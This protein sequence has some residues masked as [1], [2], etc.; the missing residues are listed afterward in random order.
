MQL[1]LFASLFLILIML[2]G[3]GNETPQPQEKIQKVGMLS[4]SN[5]EESQLDEQT[6]KFNEEHGITTEAQKTTYYNT[7]NAMQMGLTA[8]NI[9]TIRTYGSVADYMV[10]QNSELQIKDSQAIQLVDNF[11]CA[12][13][14]GD[15]ELKN[16]FDAAIDA[17][18]DDGTLDDLVKRYIKF[19][20]DDDTPSAVAMPHFDGAE[21]IKVGVTGDLPP[22][23]LVLTDGTPAGFN[24]AVLAEIS[25]RINK[26]IEL[27]VI[28]SDARAAALVSGR[29]DVIF[30]VI[31]PEGVSPY[32]TNSD[33]PAGVA[34]T[35]SYYKDTVVDVSL[36]GAF[37]GM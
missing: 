22:L 5:I 37:S 30:W 16:E 3:C 17:M 26:N 13:R 20:V 27:V 10:K 25:K 19:A 6:K 21:I 36:S 34:L 8:G 31:T 12:M 33:T 28:E 18:K 23:D 32:P 9:D 11:S 35:Q 15:A 14:E 4:R 24:T 2:T 29:V 7:F 1:K